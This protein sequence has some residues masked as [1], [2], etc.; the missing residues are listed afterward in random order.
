METFSPPLDQKT[1]IKHLIE[2]RC[3][4]PQFKHTIETS[5][6]VYHKFVVF[7][8]INSDGSIAPS[9]SQCQNCGLVHR[10]ME[11]NQST[12]TRKDNVL[13]QSTTDFEQNLPEQIG[14][15]LKEHNV[16]YPTW[17]EVNF[18]FEN[19]VWGKMVVLKKEQIEEFVTGKYLLILGEKLWKVHTFQEENTNIV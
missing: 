17:Q 12:V 4:L 10:V 3:F 15:I 8:I 19:K 7:S 5:N 2:C 16:D 18:I 1:Y 13:Q 6:P 11:V 9:L 14:S